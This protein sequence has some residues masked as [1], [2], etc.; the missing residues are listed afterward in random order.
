MPNQSWTFEF[1]DGAPDDVYTDASPLGFQ[2]GVVIVHG[3]LGGIE[4]D[5]ITPEDRIEA[6][7]H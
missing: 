5:W 6:I 3:T 7:H 2:P 4:D 1:N